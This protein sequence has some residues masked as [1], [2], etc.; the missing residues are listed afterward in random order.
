MLWPGQ[1][2]VWTN[3]V[4]GNSYLPGLCLPQAEWVVGGE[5][6]SYTKECSH[7]DPPLLSCSPPSSPT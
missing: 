3:Q 5:E 1:S 2:P 7:Q 6:Q 4:E